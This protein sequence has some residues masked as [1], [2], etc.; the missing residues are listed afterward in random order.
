MLA[1]IVKDIEHGAV[2]GI[3]AEVGAASKVLA[4]DAQVPAVE[5][6]G[7]CERPLFDRGDLRICPGI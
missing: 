5:D 1:G 2:T 3:V 7:R 4:S 6:E